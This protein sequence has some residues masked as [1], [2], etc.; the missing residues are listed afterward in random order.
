MRNINKKKERIA[1]R[2]FDFG[3]VPQCKW[4]KPVKLP[5]GITIEACLVN[6]GSG[7]NGR[8]C[9]FAGQNPKC[10]YYTPKKRWGRNLYEIAGDYLY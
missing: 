2:K 9:A 3:Q 8:T 5:N 6:K 4:N 10:R 1:T 7:R